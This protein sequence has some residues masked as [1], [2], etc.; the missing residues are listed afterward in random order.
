MYLLEDLMRIARREAN[1]LKIDPKVISAIATVESGWRPASARYERSFSYLSE[2]ERWAK[3]HGITKDTEIMFQKT[4][5]GLMQVMGGTAR[6][7]GYKGWLPNICDPELGVQIGCEY[8]LKTC[9]E[10]QDV[11]DQLAAYN[12]GSIKKRSDGS[13]RNQDYVDKALEIYDRL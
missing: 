11:K 7:I 8:F 5:W 3:L 12:G 1:I 13:Y 6:R 4:S 10:Y 9:S 2:P